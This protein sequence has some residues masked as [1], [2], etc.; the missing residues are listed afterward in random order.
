[1]LHVRQLFACVTVGAKIYAI[2]GNETGG[3]AGGA[4]STVNSFVP[5]AAA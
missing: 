5:G 3:A 4:V 2:G 1:M